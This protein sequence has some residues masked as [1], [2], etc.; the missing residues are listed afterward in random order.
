MYNLYRQSG[1]FEQE[2]VMWATPQLI[3]NIM[4]ENHLE[5][6]LE[7]PALLEE[8]HK[9]YEYL[10]ENNFKVESY[11]APATDITADIEQLKELGI[12]GEEIT[13]Q[14]IAQNQLKAKEDY[15]NKGK[16]DLN[17]LFTQTK[18]IKNGI[19]NLEL[20]KQMQEKKEE[21]EKERKKKQREEEDYKRMVGKDINEFLVKNKN[22]SENGSA[23]LLN[24]KK[25]RLQKG[26][27][28]KK[29]SSKSDSISALLLSDSLQSL[30]NPQKLQRQSSQI[31]SSDQI[32]PHQTQTEI[33]EKKQQIDPTTN[34]YSPKSTQQ[35]LSTQDVAQTPQNTPQI[36][37]NTI[38]ESIS[39]QMGLTQSISQTKIAM[40]K[41]ASRAQTQLNKNPYHIE[42]ILTEDKKQ[43]PKA[44]E[45]PKKETALVK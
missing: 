26:G 45:V 10:V 36:T 32:S 5:P 40:L 37:T 41:K 19:V 22:S 30:L 21:E 7:N 35:E 14:K 25:N 20:I 3:V 18:D 31:Q 6:D 1:A 44:K 24:G 39:T 9:F 23:S 34:K 38:H 11:K 27:A 43:V 13:D 42:L 28:N 15:G 12:I 33:I 2:S 17:S 16:A 4:R 29:Q 8:P